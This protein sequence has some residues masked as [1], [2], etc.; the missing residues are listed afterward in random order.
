[1]AER[2]IGAVFFKGMAVLY[3]QQLE[4]RLIAACSST[5]SDRCTLSSIGCEFGRGLITQQAWANGLSMFM[6]IALRESRADLTGF[7]FPDL[8]GLGNGHF[9]NGEDVA[10]D[11]DAK[12]PT[13]NTVY[14]SA[15]SVLGLLYA[16]FVGNVGS[17]PPVTLSGVT[18]TMLWDALTGQLPGTLLNRVDRLWTA[19]AQLLGP[20]N[21]VIFQLAPAF[22]ANKMA[23]KATLP[24]DGASLSPAVSPTFSWTRNG[25]TTCPNSENDQFL[26]M[27]SR[28]GFRN[29]LVK[30]D[31][32]TRGVTQY[33]PTIRSGTA[34]WPAG[35]RPR[36][37]SG[38][39]RPAM[40]P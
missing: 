5:R 30:L 19:A 40:R 3:G 1:M 12:A 2:S 13:A 4:S 35:P 21:P 36:H 31:V 34:S 29:H 9:K 37:I 39:W 33:T 16:L 10:I 38:W 25:D 28:D 7:P 11:I 27:F 14:Q 6:A 22:V 8:A 24:V 20:T 17:D 15:S 18:P 23:P 32:P 26:L